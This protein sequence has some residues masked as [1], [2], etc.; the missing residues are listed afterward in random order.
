M[1]VKDTIIIVFKNAEIGSIFTKEEIVDRVRKKD[2]INKNS[3][4]PGDYCYNRTND[5]IDFNKYPH[6]FEFLED[7][8]YK[9]LGKNYNYT[10]K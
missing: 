6:I 5:G 1:T 3:I 9:Y 4:T 8:K 10:G 7:G 2:D